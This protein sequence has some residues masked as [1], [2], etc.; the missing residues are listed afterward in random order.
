MFYYL[1]ILY[2][3]LYFLHYIINLLLI[4]LYYII[5][6]LFIYKCFLQIIQWRSYLIHAL[7]NTSPNVKAVDKSIDIWVPLN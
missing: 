7:Y 6:V 2:Y 1:F 4:Y 3:L 5:Y